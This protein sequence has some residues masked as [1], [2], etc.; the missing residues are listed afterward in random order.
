LIG[1]ATGSGRDDDRRARRLDGV[2]GIVVPL[3]HDIRGS[4]RDG[5]APMKI[6]AAVPAAAPRRIVR[7]FMWA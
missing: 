3:A 2:L 1:P 4:G 5:R 6:V 7:V